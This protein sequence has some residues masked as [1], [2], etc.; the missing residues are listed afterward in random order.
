MKFGSCDA[1]GPCPAPAVAAGY[2]PPPLPEAALATPSLTATIAP[3]LRS[4]RPVAIWP[5]VCAALIFAM[6]VIGGVTRLTESGLS[7]TEWKPVAG[8]LPPLSDGA[9]QEEFGKYQRTDQ[10]RLINQGM[11]LEEFKSIFWWEFV[12]RLW[13]RL[14]GIAFFVP[15]VWFLATGRVR[16][17]PRAGS[18][19]SSCSARCKGRWAGTW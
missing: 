6:V 18:P 14:I 11:S 15:Y 19:A 3:A 16:G 5:F 10:Y 7:I 2:G 9:W 8:A 4:Q 12:H 1:V 13:G 17:T